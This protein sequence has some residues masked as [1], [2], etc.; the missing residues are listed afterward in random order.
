MAIKQIDK[1]MQ[2]M[3]KNQSTAISGGY[4]AAAGFG[5]GQAKISSAETELKT[6]RKNYRN[7]KTS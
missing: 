7:Q 5:A 1:Q 2:G 3:D 4:S 6:Q